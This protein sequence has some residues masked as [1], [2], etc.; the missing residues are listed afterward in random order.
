MCG[1]CDLCSG[2]LRKGAALSTAAEDQLCPTA[3]IQR[4]YIEDPYFEYVIDENLCIACGKCVHGC[5]AFGNGSLFLQIKQEL[6]SHCNQCNIA[7]NCPAQ[8]ISRIDPHQPYR[9]KGVS[10]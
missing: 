2:Y 8:A 5:G 4:S 1:Y 6:C 9:L 3:A 10:G 7:A